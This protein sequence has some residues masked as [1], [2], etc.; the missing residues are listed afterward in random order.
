MTR[1]ILNNDGEKPSLHRDS[2]PR[3]LDKLCLWLSA[4]PFVA[5][6]LISDQPTRA[7]SRGQYYRRP[8]RLEAVADKLSGTQS[9]LS[10]SANCNVASANSLYVSLITI[11]SFR[12]NP[13]KASPAFRPPDTNMFIYSKLLRHKQSMNLI[14]NI[15]TKTILAKRETDT[16]F[17]FS[18]MPRKN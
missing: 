1:V 11:S 7:I 6:Q 14:D 2:N 8:R 16:V 12:P 10:Q 13:N 9:W 17:Q 4:S 18:V 15:E 5:L 3:R